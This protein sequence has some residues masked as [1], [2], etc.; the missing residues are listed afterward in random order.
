MGINRK[1]EGK[2]GC[3]IFL[4]IVVMIGYIAYNAGPPYYR[5]VQFMDEVEAKSRRA[6]V[7]GWSDERLRQ[8]IEQMAVSLN[9]PVM[10]KDIKISKSG[11][12]LIVRIEYTLSLDFIFFKYPLER[13]MEFASLRSRF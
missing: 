3:L 7:D 6:A 1:G 12:N 4:V 2:L 11:Y 9:Q 13:K 8:D 5:S 10:P